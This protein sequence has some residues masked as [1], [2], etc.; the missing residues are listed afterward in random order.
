[1]IQL[2]PTL[3]TKQDKK[4]TQQKTGKGEIIITNHSRQIP[5]P[6]PPFSLWRGWTPSPPT[7][8]NEYT[9]HTPDTFSLQL[10]QVERTLKGHFGRLV[11]VLCRCSMSVCLPFSTLS[12][13]LSFGLLF[14]HRPLNGWSFGWIRPYYGF[15]G[16]ELWLTDPTNQSTDG[17]EGS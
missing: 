4:Y 7:P 16:F 8:F 10:L 1:M 9:S 13:C 6:S 14:D 12:V 15:L 11:F 2:C 17:H 3:L 5:S